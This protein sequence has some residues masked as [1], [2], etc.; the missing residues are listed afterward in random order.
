MSYFEDVNTRQQDTGDIDAFGRTRVSQ[1]STQIDIKQVHDAQPLLVNTVVNGSAT[2]THSTSEAKTTIATAASGDYAIAQTNQR[3]NY[4]TGK[5]Q[6]IFKTFYDFDSETNVSKMFGYFSSSTT[7][8]YNTDYDGFWLEASSATHYIVTSRT[9]TETSRVARADWYDPLDGTGP[10]GLDIGDLD[11]NVIIQP[12]FEWLGVGRVRY[13]YVSNGMRNLVHAVDFTNGSR[14]FTSAGWVDIDATFKGVYMSSPNQPLRWEVRQTGAGSSSTTYICASV[15]SEGSI[16]SIGKDG[17]IDDDGTHLN[18]NSTSQW[19][20][21]IGLKLQAAKLD[22]FI[23]VLGAS[24]MSVTNDKFLYRILYNPTYNGTVTY[25]D[26]T[27]YSLSYGLGVT[28]NTISTMGSILSS[29]TGS[30]NT[31][32]GFDLKTAIRLGAQ[33]DGT[34]DEIVIAV[35]PLS[36]QLDIHRTID[37][38]QIT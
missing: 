13:F 4:Q 19:Y 32:E 20:Y 29:G 33:I 25:T 17:G 14:R 35:K 22:S 28:S 31:N 12:D 37:F 34:L 3:F 27:D 5:S 8:P 23:D 21:A 16:N 26:V 36:S 11:L 38:R 1:V 18:A 10:S 6:E 15:G 9:G 30:D 7:A 2:I 24:L